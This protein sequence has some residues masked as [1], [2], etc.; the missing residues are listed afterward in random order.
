MLSIKKKK[1][2]TNGLILSV[3]EWLIVSIDSIGINPSI[4]AIY[5]ESND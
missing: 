5:A 1:S 4:H 3:S 2:F